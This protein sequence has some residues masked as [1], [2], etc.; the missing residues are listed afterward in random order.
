MWHTIREYEALGEFS[1]NGML[2]RSKFVQSIREDFFILEFFPVQIDTFPGRTLG[3]NP[4]IE[5][6]SPS[7]ITSLMNSIEIPYCQSLE[8][9]GI[10]L[11]ATTTWHCTL[12]LDEI[13]IY[14]RVQSSDRF[15]TEHIFNW[16]NH[17]SALENL[18]ISTDAWQAI[19][20]RESPFP[21]DQNDRKNV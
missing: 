21:R 9:L 13:T 18:T 4:R 7:T 16:F 6:K 8:C 19:H 3:G 15:F 5:R 10:V 14:A 11:H 1:E 12:R 2:S 17:Q 20:R